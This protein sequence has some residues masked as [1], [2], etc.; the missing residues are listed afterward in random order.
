MFRRLIV[1]V[2]SV[3]LVDLS[4]VSRPSLLPGFLVFVPFQYGSLSSGKFPSL[5]SPSLL[6]LFS[7]LTR[8][9]L[10]FLL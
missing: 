2:P 10:R 6:S 4:H 5:S 3:T 9:N 7:H 1:P 8:W